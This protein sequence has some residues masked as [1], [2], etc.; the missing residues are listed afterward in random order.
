[1]ISIAVSTRNLV[2]A[3]VIA[4]CAVFAGCDSETTA[5]PAPAT[6]SGTTAEGA[7][8]TFL[9]WEEG[10]AI[11]IVDPMM[12]EHRGP[13]GPSTSEPI[14]GIHGSAKSEDGASYDWQLETTDGRTAKFT[15]NDVQY[16]LANG[17]LFVVYANGEHIRV[18]QLDED[19]SHVNAADAQA[20][21]AFLR[22]KPDVTKLLTAQSSEN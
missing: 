1:M 21:Q 22:G 7:Y 5:P 14:P 18:Q 15:I 6:A 9:K 16:D 11:M 20:C 8:F 17:T 3:A 4:S 12:N 2:F 19:L 13:T 10:L